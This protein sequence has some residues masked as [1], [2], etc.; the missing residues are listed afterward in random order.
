MSSWNGTLHVF[1]WPLKVHI[2]DSLNQPNQTG[3]SNGLRKTQIKSTFIHDDIGDSIYKFEQISQKF[4]TDRSTYCGRE[5]M[6][7]GFIVFALD[8]LLSNLW[9]WKKGHRLKTEWKNSSLLLYE[10]ADFHC[11]SF[12]LLLF[13]S[14]CTYTSSPLF[15]ARCSPFNVHNVLSYRHT[16]NVA[17]IIKIICWCMRSC[18]LIWIQTHSP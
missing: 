9:H 7:I 1:C 13:S 15:R 14:D 12:L 5:V 10:W 2:S 11:F 17:I 6:A 18:W 8:N 4:E 3:M 16:H